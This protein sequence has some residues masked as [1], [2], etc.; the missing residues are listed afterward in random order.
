M[1]VQL[2]NRIYFGTIIFVFVGCSHGTLGVRSARYK[3]TWSKT[4]VQ[5]LNE[6]N[7]GY[8]FTQTSGSTNSLE[9]NSQS[10]ITAGGGFGKD[11][12]VLDINYFIE[13]Y[14]DIV[15]GYSYTGTSSGSG[16][17]RLTVLNSGIEI[18]GGYRIN[19][20]RPYVGLRKDAFV[21]SGINGSLNWQSNTVSMTS[22]LYGL[23]LDVPLTQKLDLS[24]QIDQ[25]TVIQKQSPVDTAQKMTLH[26]QIK[27]DI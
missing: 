16:N 26:A 21:L 22:L 2:L 14:P 27:W 5:Q 8:S 24:L 7:P 6:Q 15:Y 13:K 19:W 1:L 10:G 18:M 4:L 25:G 20:F 3:E 17:Q 11:D 23:G 9:L 12:W